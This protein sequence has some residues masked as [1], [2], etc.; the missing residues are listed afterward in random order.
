MANS[1]LVDGVVDAGGAVAPAPMVE[2]AAAAIGAN[3]GLVVFAESESRL[4]GLT[5]FNLEVENQGT[6]HAPI[7]EVPA[8]MLGIDPERR[9][10]ISLLDTDDGLAVMVGGSVA[11][12]DHALVVA[13]PVLESIVIHALLLAEHG[14][15]VLGMDLSPVAIERA[16]EK[17]GKRGLGAEFV[18]GDALQLDAL[19]RRFATIVDSALFHVFDD[20]DRARYVR[21]LA[22]AIEPGGVLYVLCFSDQVP[23]T[24]GPRRVSQAE[25]RTAFGDGW[26]IEVIEDARIEV[27][28]DWMPE[29]PHAWLAHIIRN[30]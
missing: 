27:R 20:P 11:G 5:G 17:A 9:L 21:S 7:I 28:D 3:P 6:S 4:G 15:E 8:G 2:A 25:L 18:V 19:G 24:N 26:V 30:A 16:R 12:W 29:N 10:W 14:M 1:A 13:E 22:S 23:G